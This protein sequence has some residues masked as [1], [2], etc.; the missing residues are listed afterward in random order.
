MP[1]N[2]FN[3]IKPVDALG[4]ITSLSSVKRR[5]KRKR[6]K[7]QQHNNAQAELEQLNDS[8][9]EQTNENLVNQDNKN[10]EEDKIDFCA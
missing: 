1:D 9:D 8:I 3:L 5:E 2:D 10:T 7:N 6:K 4:N